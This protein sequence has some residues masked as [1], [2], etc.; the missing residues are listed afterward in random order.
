[1]LTWETVKVVASVDGHEYVV[2]LDDDGD[3]VV[4]LDGSIHEVYNSI[5]E[6]KEYCENTA[7]AWR[8]EE[9]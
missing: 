2:E 1:M 7:V 6:A 4:I 8:E 5:E 3:W 9:E